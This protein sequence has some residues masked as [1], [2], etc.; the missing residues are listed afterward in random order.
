MLESTIS[1]LLL[2]EAIVLA[3]VLAPKSGRNDAP[4]ILKS[5]VTLL[6]PFLCG[7]LAFKLRSIEWPIV[8]QLL[9]GSVAWLVGIWLFIV[10]RA[11]KASS[12]GRR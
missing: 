1:W 12:W 4:A 9:I 10:F 5:A 2:F 8:N 6:P 7:V 3:I 11:A